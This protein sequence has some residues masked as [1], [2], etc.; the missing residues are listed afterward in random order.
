MNAFPEFRA[1][2]RSLRRFIR[3]FYNDPFFLYFD[4]P[5][6]K[7]SRMLDLSHQPRFALPPVETE[8]PTPKRKA[9][10]PKRGKRKR[11]QEDEAL[12]RSGNSENSAV[13][14]QSPKRLKTET[15]ETL[16]RWEEESRMDWLTAKVNISD[17]GNAIEISAFLPGLDKNDLQI[18]V[19]QHEG[20]NVMLLSAK[21]L[22]KASLQNEAF[23]RVSESYGTFTKYIPLPKSVDPTTIT[24]SFEN[25]KLVVRVPKGPQSTPTKIAISDKNTNTSSSNRNDKNSASAEK[26]AVE[27]ATQQSGSDH[28]AQSDKTNACPTASSQD[29]VTTASNNRTTSETNQSAEK[30]RDTPTEKTAEATNVTTPEVT[31]HPTTTLP[32]LTPLKKDEV[33]IEDA[34]N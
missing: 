20:R 16:K 2:E 6:F 3:E 12:A 21:K 23:Y 30:M 4:M 32:I 5:A 18:E 11:T 15:D 26:S 1:F 33:K 17:V 31:T 25:Q 7:L 13:D 14:A 22:Q 9:S 28:S 19:E 24:A 10:K 29:V 34:V 27:S 8:R